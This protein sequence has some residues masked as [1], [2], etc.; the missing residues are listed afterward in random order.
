MTQKESVEKDG[1]TKEFTRVVE[2]SLKPEVVE[3]TV[4]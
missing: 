2:G 3:E 1:E 4:G